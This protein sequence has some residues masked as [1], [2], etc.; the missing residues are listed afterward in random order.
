[1]LDDWF[2]TV[3]LKIT[4]EEFERLPRT[5]GYKNEYYDGQCVLTPRPRNCYAI[6]NLAQFQTP[7]PISDREEIVIRPLKDSDWEP[8]GEWCGFAFHRVPPFDSLTDEEKKEAGRDCMEHT[9][10]GGNG[11][12]IAEASMVAVD[13]K[14]DPLERAAHRAKNPMNITQTPGG[15]IGTNR[16]CPTAPSPMVGRRTWTGSS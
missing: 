5:L 12:M 3:R 16:H 8:L 6:L 9:R 7:P 1:M 10:N 2:R 13:E 15:T 4:F 11:P 14:N